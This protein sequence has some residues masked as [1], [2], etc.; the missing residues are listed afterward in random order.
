MNKEAVF[1]ALSELCA[2]AD[3][4]KELGDKGREL[5]SR[6]FSTQRMVDQLEDVYSKVLKKS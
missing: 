1:K 5:V 4:R 2:S 3:L 6:L